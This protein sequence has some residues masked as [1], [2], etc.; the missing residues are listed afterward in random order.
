MYESAI[1]VLKRLNQYGYEAY[2][3]GG[4]PRDQ[5]LHRKS[6][7]VDICTSARPNEVIQL[8]ENVDIRD[9]RYGCIR[10]RIGE[11]SFSVTTF[12]KEY[13]YYDGRHVE[14]I[15]Y[16]ETLLEDLKRRDFIMNTLCIDKDGKYV[17]W[18]GAKQDIQNKI[19]RSVGNSMEKFNEDY[20]RILR[21]IR[22]STVLDF[23]LD[24]E[25][26]EAIFKCKNNVKELSYFRKKEELDKIFKSSNCMKGIHLLEK[27]VLEDEL[28][29]D[30]SKVS[31]CS[32]YLGM[33]AQC[34][35]DFT[36]PFTK[37]EKEFLSS[38]QKILLDTPKVEYLKQYGKEVCFAADEIRLCTEYHE[39]YK[40]L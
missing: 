37:K 6:L 25:V 15:S 27:F 34:I 17:D 22:F 31:Y 7:D 1:E 14:E 21:A 20:L 2:I 23:S 39:L 36:Y 16:V 33:W 5:V 18:Y 3:V 9:S 40:T 12:R 10:V 30:F 28:H 13:A 32:N 29:L 38:L 24:I 19:I 11:Y 4:Y 26:V 35:T 8:F